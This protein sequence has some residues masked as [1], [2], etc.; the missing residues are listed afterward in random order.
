MQDYRYLCDH[1][2][3]AIYKYA[4]EWAREACYIL[5]TIAQLNSYIQYVFINHINP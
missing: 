5:Q 1:A 3:R 4:R 2:K